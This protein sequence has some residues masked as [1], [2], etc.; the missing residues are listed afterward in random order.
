MTKYFK[1]LNKEGLH[2]DHHYTDGMNILTQPF[3]DRPITESSC[4]V[5]GFY[6]T[7]LDHIHKFYQFGCYLTEITL[8]END[9]EFKIVHDI[10][11]GKYRSNRVIIGKKYWLGDINT[12][13]IFNLDIKNY[14]IYFACYHGL[15]AILQWWKDSGL[16]F[17]YDLGALT[18]ASTHGHVDVL[19]W[20]KDSGLE[21]KYDDGVLCR[22]CKNKQTD[23][24]KW[25]LDSGLQ[26]IG[27]SRDEVYA[28]AY[29]GTM[30]WL[31]DD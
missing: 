1:I 27:Y 20:W 17:E 13:L 21:M 25:W 19:Q 11:S 3:N 8:P 7:T 9:P 10:G 15:V 5:G 14:P 30:F 22:A 24:L 18:I 28:A 29:E 6:F 2:F 12:F 16:K 4:A 31:M 26:L 23:V